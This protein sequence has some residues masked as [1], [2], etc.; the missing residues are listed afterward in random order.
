MIQVLRAYHAALI[1]GGAPRVRETPE[2]ADELGWQAR[3]FSG[4]CGRKFTTTAGDQVVVRDFG[5]W[6]REAG[7]DFVRCT[8]GVGPTERSGAIEVDLEAA[9]WEQHRHAINPDYE[10]VVLHV[11]VRRPSKPH[12][13]RTATHREV[14]Q[15]CLADHQPATEAWNAAAPARAGR[16][17]AP[18]R[19]LSTERLT[20]LL[21]VAARR[22]MERKGAV[23][24][25]MIEA[26]GTDAALFEAVAVTLGYKSNKLPFQLLAQRLPR[27]EA[28][29]P[30]GEALLFGLAGFLERP[31]P[32]PGAPRQYASNLW[33]AWWKERAAR[34]AS[35]LPAG[36]WR[37]TGQRPANHPLR[38]L[39]A[40]TVIA[41]H[42]RQIRPALESG[43]EAKLQTL[44]GRLEHPFWSFHTTWRSPRRTGPL[45]LL[46]PDRIR[47]I[48]AN[49]ALPL[50]LA[51]GRETS[52]RELPAGPANTSLR[53]VAARLFGGP[54]PRTLPRRLYVHQG[55]LQIYADFCL[56]DHG[57]CAQCRFPALVGRLG[58]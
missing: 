37:L 9:G 29:R 15:I 24:A 13:A 20:E 56:R 32:P 31:E 14:P 40:L 33:A 18:L 34:T 5:E 12:F 38:R 44:L 7:P 21:A 25:A 4:A 51:R 10:N 11:V 22:R 49:V 46:G 53:V 39:G 6:N 35:I 1:A 45:A 19:E 30:Q 28:A 17:C 36:A 52:W 26:R 58:G 57:E 42:W 43:S 47:E 3:W 54:L 2:P 27:R 55:L 41:R 23:I 48:F 16:C 50:A 8:V